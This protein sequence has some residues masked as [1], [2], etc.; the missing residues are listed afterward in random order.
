METAS[1]S[2]EVVVPVRRRGRGRVL[3]LVAVGGVACLLTVWIGSYAWEMRAE[4]AIREDLKAA[5]PDIAD[6]QWTCSSVASPYG[7]DS[8]LYNCEV[9]SGGPDAPTVN[10]E[11]FASPERIND[12]IALVEEQHAELAR[13]DTSEKDR[14]LVFLGAGDWAP[15][16][17][18]RTW[19][20]VATWRVDDAE[21]GYPIYRA[22]YRYAGRP[23]GVTVFGRSLA[24][25]DD[26]TGSLHLPA[27]DQLPR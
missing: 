23:F 5:F 7:N 17:D 14:K 6:P 22:S 4:G 3:G 13:Q 11:A 26:V 25:L 1:P 27:P 9:R 10:F 20:R 24:E 16:S 21:P 19:G 2:R 8:Y 12:T 15:S 18:R